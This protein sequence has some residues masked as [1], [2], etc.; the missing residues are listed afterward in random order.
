MFFLLDKKRG[1]PAAAAFTPASI[2]G[3]TAWYDFSDVSTLFT[4]SART[5][6]VTADGDAI[7]GVTD[8]SGNARH[9][10]NTDG[11]DRP[12]YKINIQNGR[13]V[14]R[15]DGV[16]DLLYTTFASTIS[17]AQFYAILAIDIIGAFP[18]GGVAMEL[19]R[20]T[21]TSPIFT[22]LAET[23][24]K[25]RHRNNAATI[26][27]IDSGDTTTATVILEYIWDGSNLDMY[28]NGASIVTPAS[29]TGT[30]TIDVLTIGASYVPSAGT[31]K[32]AFTNA[33]QCEF[34]YFSSVPSAENRTLLRN[35]LNSKW[36]VY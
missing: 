9:L 7:G 5:T 8:K 30:T 34:I 6:A 13:S 11:T 22:I 15:T 20:S 35:Y 32:S 33:N 31:P 29:A 17:P 12:L 27:T 28:K 1:A 21:S 4:D 36:A 23:T 18:S 26:L 19:R 14:A 24:W 16:N 25:V 2:S 3:L 10:G